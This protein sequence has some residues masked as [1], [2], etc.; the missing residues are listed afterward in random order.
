MKNISIKVLVFLLVGVSGAG[1]YYYNKHIEAKKLVEISTNNAIAEREALTG[2]IIAFETTI[3][4]LK[5]S[6]DS[7]DKKLLIAKKELNIKD[8]K[9]ISMQ[10]TIDHF[11]TTDSIIIK[12]DTLFRNSINIDTTIINSKYYKLNL[13]LQYPSLIVVTPEFSIE[14]ATFFTSKKETIKERKRWPWYIFQ[15]KH[16]VVEVKIKD[17][18]PFL[19]RDSSQSK[20]IYIIK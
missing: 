20:Y 13:K 14:R 8:S 7:L 19:I 15:K 10:Y 4:Q 17:S 12:R 1:Y 16:T 9:L 3:K 11:R 6:N 5:V 18:N 2:K